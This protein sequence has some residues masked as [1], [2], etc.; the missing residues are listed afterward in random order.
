MIEAPHYTS[1]GAK[2]DST[3][4]L[5]AEY[6][7]GPVTVPVLHQTVRVFLNNELEGSAAT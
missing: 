4:A 2:R 1:A 3:F 5:P 6:S 7:D